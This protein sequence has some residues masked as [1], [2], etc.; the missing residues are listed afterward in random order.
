M[1]QSGGFVESRDEGIVDVGFRGSSFA[2]GVFDPDVVSRFQIFEKEAPEVFYE[3]V[4]GH[5]GGSFQG[6]AFFIE[7]RVER[8]DAAYGADAFVVIEGRQESERVF[9]PIPAF[10]VHF[11]SETLSKRLLVVYFSSMAEKRHLETGHGAVVR[12]L[13]EERVFGGFHNYRALLKEAFKRVSTHSID[14][15]SQSGTFL[16]IYFS[17]A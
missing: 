17:T 4:V 2:H 12:F 15:P 16:E 9:E 14:K 10:H 3:R 1:D 13:V 5:V 8:S 6:N 7:K 11:Y